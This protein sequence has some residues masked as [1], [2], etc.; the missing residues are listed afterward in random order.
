ME[1]N[2]HSNEEEILY[3]LLLKEYFLNNSKLNYKNWRVGSGRKK[4][5]NQLTHMD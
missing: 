1:E 2:K 4:G 5:I 3:I